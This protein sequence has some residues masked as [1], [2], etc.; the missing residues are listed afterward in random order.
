MT[1]NTT[2]ALIIPCLNEE[3]TIAKV[4]REFQSVIG[5]V[6]IY[7]IDNG[8]VDETASIAAKEGAKVLLQPLRGKGNAIR[9]AFS[10]VQ[11]SV[12]LIVDGD[13][14]YDAKSALD[15][16][17]KL[18]R[19]QLDMVVG[20][21]KHE[22]KEA[23]RA[24]HKLGNQIF[25]K[26]FEIIFGNQFSD[27]FSGYRVFSHAFVKSF[28]AQSSGFDIET[29]LS[30]HCINLKLRTGEIETKYIERPIGS[31]S[32]LNTFLDGLLILSSMIRLLRQNKP[33]LFYGFFSM[34][35]TLFSIILSFPIILTYLET[36]LVPRFPSL[37]VA[38]SS[39]IV[40]CLILMTGVILQTM[41]SFQAE[42]RHL[43]YLAAKAQHQTRPIK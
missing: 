17:N 15:M 6:D 32:K 42:N 36:G 12:Y 1:K 7:V 8:S 10:E 28:P 19:E 24:G 21:R 16:I 35:A 18:N 38:A 4:I 31:F 27:I 9:L 39:L 41:L 40:A 33:M 13:H 29:E 5:S 20:V 37:I 22:K 2:V 34:I 25:N 23:Y 11:A 30:V 14:T 43:S 26:L 3:V